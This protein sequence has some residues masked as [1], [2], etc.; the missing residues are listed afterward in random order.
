[1]RLDYLQ[2]GCAYAAKSEKKIVLQ[3]AEHSSSMRISS[4]KLL[5]QLAPAREGSCRTKE[6]PPR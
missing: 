6:Q 1:M 2:Q 5:R 3:K 4:R